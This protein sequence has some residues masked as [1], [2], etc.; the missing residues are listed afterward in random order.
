MLP[1]T[2]RF[3]WSLSL[4][5]NRLGE[6]DH[7]SVFPVSGS[8][9]RRR[10]TLRTSVDVS[11]ANA[12]AYTRWIGPSCFCWTM[13]L[14][15]T[16]YMEWRVRMRRRGVARSRYVILAGSC[17]GED[18]ESSVRK[19]HDWYQG[20]HFRRYDGYAGRSVVD[21]WVQCRPSSGWFKF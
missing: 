6:K 21:K 11:R 16:R 15:C 5:S 9:W 20:Q 19:N 12:A 8:S 13:L 18:I 1:F 17:S 10:S 7:T 14:H 4:N 3:A 2:C